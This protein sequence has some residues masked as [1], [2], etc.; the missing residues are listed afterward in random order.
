M[1]MHSGDIMIMSGLS[2]LLY[3][4]VPRVL[5]NLE[6]KLLPSCLELPLSADLPLDS[7]IEPCSQED[8]EVC[9]RY[10]QGSRVN[11]TVRQVLAEG[12][13][14]PTE[15]RTDQ[16]LDN[17]FTDSYHEENHEIKKHRSDIDS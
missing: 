1:F 11:M 4:A 5:P 7:V 13:N 8:W 9:A 15:T 16:E 2:R 10:L 12:Q 6:G 17:V 3:H 14:F